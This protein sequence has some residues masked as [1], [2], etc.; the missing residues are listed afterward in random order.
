MLNCQKKYPAKLLLYGEY[1][2]TK[3]GSA[4]A[5]PLQNNYAQWQSRFTEGQLQTSGINFMLDYLISSDEGREI[6][7]TQKLETSLNDG[8]YLNSNIPQGYGLGSSGSVVAAVYEEF[9]KNKAEDLLVLKKELSFIENAFHGNSSGIDP[10]VSYLNSSIKISENGTI[11]PIILDIKPLGFFMID[12]GV[13][14]KTTP[15]VQLFEE[16]IK[17]EKDFFTLLI[18]LKALNDTAIECTLNGEKND[19]WMSMCHISAF[20]LNYFNEMILPEWSALWSMGLTSQEFALKI[21]GAGGGGMILGMYNPHL[22]NKKIFK[23]IEII[24]L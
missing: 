20:Q 11:S 22:T 3:G 13:S 19:L 10:L 23:N 14:R 18:G 8:W 16:K 21:C 7:D 2:V 17:N 4:L 24:N 5:I 15:F 9:C 1:T 6:I 12:T